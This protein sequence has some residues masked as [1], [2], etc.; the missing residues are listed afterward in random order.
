[1]TQTRQ[2]YEAQIVRLETQS[3]R[4][5]GWYQFRLAIIVAIGFLA[6]PLSMAAGPLGAAYRGE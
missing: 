1:M 3:L 2:Q 6:L 5:P 4:H